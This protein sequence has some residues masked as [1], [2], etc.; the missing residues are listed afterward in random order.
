VAFTQLVRLIVILELHARVVPDRLEHEEARLA[1]GLLLR[2]QQ[3]D[4]EQS[5]DRVE[6]CVADRLRRLESKAT[7]ED[8][9][10]AE[11][12]LLLLGEE[13]EAP[14]ERCAQGLLALRPVARAA[15]KELQ[16]LAESREECLGRKELHARGREL[17]RKR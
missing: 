5:L 10:P 15:A 6:A 13:L 9:Q 4:L 16:P 3:V 11:Q 2:T 14:V 17:D 7:R 8:A 12:A 1:V